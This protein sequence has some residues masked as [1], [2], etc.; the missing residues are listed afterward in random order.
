MKNL[1]NFLL[2]AAAVATVSCA[3]EIEPIENENPTPEVELVPMTFTASYD[4]S[5]PETKVAYE[6][7]A[8]VWKVGDKIMV[9]SAT[10][11]A[12]EFEATEVY[13]Q[14]AT[15]TGLTEN[16]ETYIAVYPSSAYKGYVPGEKLYVN[17][18][19]TQQAVTGTFDPEAIFC[20]ATNN[21]NE[22]SFKQACAFLKFQIKNPKGLKS[23][24]LTVNGYDNLA[25]I[26]YLEVNEVNNPE[27]RYDPKDEKLKRY[28]MITLNAPTGGFEAGKD[29]FIAM[30]AN[31][32]PTG[33]TLYF[34][35]ENTWKS[36]STDKRIFPA[37][38]ETD[39]NKMWGAKGK[40]RN[41]GVVDSKAIA[42][43]PYEAYN[44]G[45]DI[46][47]AGKAINKATYGNATLITDTS[48]N[49][50]INAGGVFFVNSNA[51]NVSLGAGINNK[52]IIIVGNTSDTRST[53][54]RSGY[55]PLPST[56]ENDYWIISNV[57]LDITNNSGYTLRANTNNTLEFL[58][59]ENCHVNIPSGTQ[60]IYVAGTDEIKNISI[61]DSEFLVGANNVNNFI[62]TDKNHTID[63]IIIDN[64][65]FYSASADA[66]ANSFCLI[67]PTYATVTNLVINKN[68]MYGAMGTK[69]VPLT[70]CYS[71]NCTITNNM[72]VVQS[73]SEGSVGMISK[74]I[75]N[76][77]NVTTN[78]CWLNNT[79]DYRIAGVATTYSAPSGTAELPGSLNGDLTGWNPNNNKFVLNKYFGATR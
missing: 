72:F 42:L 53:I 28:D 58:S 25:G 35:Y 44:I 48:E 43:T 23:V 33:I 69:D 73:V 76:T 9:I 49:K 27:H 18:K 36:L 65:V 30:R 2:A 78:R 59:F 64:N 19:E 75:S 31:S 46:I 67:A 45:F 77:M 62:K 34:E 61:N 6:E 8:T 10:G 29:Y 74:K 47:V 63:N 1:R 79:S 22:L 26:G 52:S 66:P 11:T 41:L 20:T 21:G 15:F 54:S 40:I 51:T 39:P 13:G 17:I 60:F 50:T 7:G 68:T 24:R 14:K 32:C 71:T 56:T 38:D 37:K 4:A 5:E 16:A 3:I 12:T 57:T 55:I 70:G